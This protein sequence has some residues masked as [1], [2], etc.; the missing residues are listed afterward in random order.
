MAIFA[1]GDLH[2]SLGVSKPMDVFRGWQDY[3]QRLSDNWKQLIRPEDTVVLA[4]DTSWGMKL[5]DCTKDF[6][7]LEA[8]PGQKLLLKGNHDYWW[9]TVSKMERYFAENNFTTLHFLHN[10]CLLTEGV[11]L[12]GTRSWLFDIG[13]PHDEKVMNREIGRLIMSLEAAGAEEKV[14]FLHYPPVYATAQAQEIIEVLHRYGVKRCYYGHLH[15]ASI[16]RA[17]EG[18]VDGIEYKLISAD[19]VRFC[20]VRIDPPLVTAVCDPNENAADHG[21]AGGSIV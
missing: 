11:A 2:L 5:T 6:A 18:K 10:N 14:V 21:A 19:G 20:P 4:G 8:L 16:P 15:G 13:Q 7:F 1:I 9:T 12:C 17:V 3:V